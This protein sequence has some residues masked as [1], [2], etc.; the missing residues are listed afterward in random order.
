MK[1][2]AA[3]GVLAVITTGAV[4]GVLSRKDRRSVTRAVTIGREPSDVYAHLRAVPHP[5]AG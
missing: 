4:V 2:K 1:W 5:S 3:A